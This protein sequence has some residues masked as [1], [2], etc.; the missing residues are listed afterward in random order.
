MINWEPKN[1]ILR[2]FNL[3][4]G[5]KIRQKCSDGSR[6][7]IFSHIDGMYSYCETERGG[8]IHLSAYTP[9]KKVK[10]YYKIMH[11]YKEKKSV[12]KKD[13]DKKPKKP[14]VKRGIKEKSI[15]EMDR[16]IKKFLDEYGETMRMLSDS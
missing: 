2:L 5:A 1:K 7:I 14:V 13:V 9:L 16:F 12:V 15:K 10:D 11:G 6:Y 8:V 3:K 4:Y